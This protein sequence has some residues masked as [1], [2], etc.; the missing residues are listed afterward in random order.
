MGL[1][2]T[3]IIFGKFYFHKVAFST[4]IYYIKGCN[5]KKG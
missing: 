3:G 1:A 5:V 2:K 4:Q